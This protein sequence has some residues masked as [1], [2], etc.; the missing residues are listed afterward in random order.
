MN[1][2]EEI[3]T[4]I[5]H[6]PYTTHF[7][8]E[9]G[10]TYKF[11]ELPGDETGR[12][13]IAMEKEYGPVGTSLKEDAIHHFRSIEDGGY[14]LPGKAEDALYRAVLITPNELRHIGIQ[15]LVSADDLRMAYKV[16]KMTDEKFLALQEAWGISKKDQNQVRIGKQ[17]RRWVSPELLN[18]IEKNGLMY[19][20]IGREGNH[21]NYAMALLGKKIPH[22]EILSPKEEVLTNPIMPRNYLAALNKGRSGPPW[23]A[24]S[25]TISAHHLTGNPPDEEIPTPIIHQTPKADGRVAEHLETEERA[26]AVGLEWVNRTDDDYETFQMIYTLDDGGSRWMV[27]RKPEGGI[28]GSPLAG[29]V[30]S[31]PNYMQSANKYGLGPGCP[32]CGSNYTEKTGRMKVANVD[33]P[34][35]VIEGGYTCNWCRYMWEMD[36]MDLVRAN[37]PISVI[38][39]ARS[40]DGR[41]KF[42]NAE[43]GEEVTGK[44]FEGGKITTKGG[45]WE[46]SAGKP[47]SQLPKNMITTQ[48]GFFGLQVMNVA[49]LPGYGPIIEF[50]NFPTTSAWMDGGTFFAKE[51]E[52]TSPIFLA[53]EP[54]RTGEPS[55]LVY[56]IG[57]HSVSRDFTVGKATFFNGYSKGSPKIIYEKVNISRQSNLERVENE[58]NK[59]HRSRNLYVKEGG[60]RTQRIMSVDEIRKEHSKIIREPRKANPKMNPPK[61][62]GELTLA[63]KKEIRKKWKELVNMT[64]T[65][66]QS[67]YD[68]DLG[69]TAGL[70][71]DEAKEA[72]IS[73]GRDSA[74]A[75]IKMKQTPVKEWHKHNS[76]G[77]DFWQWAQKQTS[78]NARHRGMQGPYLDEKG[79]P[80]RKLLGLWIWGHDPWRYAIKV[81]K[82]RLPKCPNVPWVGSKEKKQFGVL[83]KD[84]PTFK[85]IVGDIITVSGPSSSGKSTITK[86]LSKKMRAR[87]V[88][89]YMSRERRPNEVEGVDGIFVSKERFQDMIDTGAFTT[90]EGVNL[91]VQ[92]K[93]GEFYGRKVSD[94]M[95]ATPAIVDVNFDGL[96][97]MR[98]AFYGRTYSVFIKT[99]MGPKRRR[100]NLEKRGVHSEKEI[101]A[102]VRAG[103]GMLDTFH[104]LNFDFIARN[105]FGE[106][107]KNV[108]MI[109]SEFKKWQSAVGLVGKRKQRKYS[110]K[111]CPHPEKNTYSS[112]KSAEENISPDKRHLIRAYKCPVDGK[113][114]WHL[115]SSINPPIGFIGVK[116][117]EGYGDTAAINVE[118]GDSSTSLGRIVAATT[119]EGHKFSLKT[120]M[121]G[122]EI[123]ISQV[124]DFEG[125][126]NLVA[127][128]SLVDEILTGAIPW[129]HETYG[130]TS[131]EFENYNE[132][133]EDIVTRYAL[134]IAQHEAMHVETLEESLPYAEGSEWGLP[135]KKRRQEMADKLTKKTSLMKEHW[136][137]IATKQLIEDL[138]PVII[139][140]VNS[141]Q[142]GYVGDFILQNPEPGVLG[143]T[144]KWSPPTKNNP[145]VFE[146]EGAMNMGIQTPGPSKYHNQQLEGGLSEIPNMATKWKKDSFKVELPLR[147][148]QHSDGTYTTGFLEMYEGDTRPYTVSNKIDGDN[149]LAHFDGEET[150]IWTRRGRW[151]KDF[152]LTDQITQ[153]LQAQGVKSA[154][155][156]GELYAVDEKEMILPLSK[157]KSVTTAPKS[158]TIQ[159]DMR[160]AGFDLLELNGA[161]LQDMPYAQ[162]MEILKPLLNGDSIQVVPSYRGKGGMEAVLKAWD[163][164]MKDPNFEGLVFRFDDEAKSIKIKMKGTADLAIIGFYRGKEGGRDEHIIG[165]AGLAWMNEDGDFVYAGNSVMGSSIVEKAEL[166][167]RLLPTAID[168]PK[169][170]WGDHLVNRS[171]THDHLGKGTMTAIEPFLIG[172]FKY[173]SINYS[174]KPVYRLE[175][176]AFIKVGTAMAPTLFQA[177]FGRWRPDKDMTP[178]DLRMT[179]V[180]AE[181]KGKWKAN[182]PEDDAD[183]PGG[184][185]RFLMDG[186][187]IG[188]LTQQGLSKGGKTLLLDWPIEHPELAARLEEAQKRGWTTP[189]IPKIKPN[190]HKTNPPSQQPIQIPKVKVV[191]RFTKKMLDENPDKAFLFGDNEERKGTGGQAKVCRGKKNAYGIR[192]KRSPDMGQNAFWSDKNYESNIKMMAD[193]FMAAFRAEHST[194]VLPADGIGTGLADLKNKAPKTFKWL[195]S[196]MK[197]LAALEG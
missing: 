101:E 132:T 20:S 193:D 191:K 121:R 158:L 177:T 77:Y 104:N 48:G 152:A 24:I 141:Q 45:K 54:F 79:R 21:R 149:N 25:P 88:P 160:F 66:L 128:S 168:A 135:T 60:F 85:V 95:Q 169:A 170:K 109:A 155:L 113:V 46:F 63:R 65:E 192:T 111:V 4:P 32:R 74:L 117:Q 16:A 182:P 23:W 140:T 72:N 142:D 75:I 190:P 1:S 157:Q 174:E 58:A 180:A 163:K 82:E 171:I 126:V 68:S 93:S 33:G 129:L 183:Y 80:T 35:S 196:M 99:S 184:V 73:S 120:Q 115:T 131:I 162:R 37:P 148:K 176:G 86:A 112:K 181:G 188:S 96:R 178:Q 44:F 12:M 136:A 6:L 100:E 143:W 137:D 18:S 17:A 70:S 161:D 29:P 92:Q 59:V 71:R 173:R 83:P 10:R 195:R 64:A 187:L 102:R 2:D 67:F 97:L 39:R 139:R 9:P 55:G 119:Y 154:I 50:N 105:K 153:S 189:A 125:N 26:N 179:Q 156:M 57:M 13:I 194:L 150:V 49:L 19:P 90:K 151:R 69:K 116:G 53:S 89:S 146:G 124:M 175:H 144:I 78:F 118:S 138:D 84:N 40:E 159:K 106:I 172:E 22:L 15:E 43:T 47:L 8:F 7:D 165:G 81:K 108:S 110:N 38:P 11:D 5:I 30:R 103:T 133:K 134:T 42:F 41:T 14:G 197:Q 167:E 51:V 166:L 3:P 34:A 94:F 122:T 91:W 52:I 87:M 145:P 164:G 27:V 61:K 36:S 98:K 127:L 76:K 147:S 62:S 56:A 31:S 28:P 185:E 130:D 123:T 107:E 186:I 114:H